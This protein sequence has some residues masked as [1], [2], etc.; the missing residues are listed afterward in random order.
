MVYIAQTQGCVVLRNSEPE[1]LPL[2]IFPL[3][4]QRRNLHVMLPKL[5][6]RQLRH[7]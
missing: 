7:N 2:E 4:K 3:D 5:I 6:Q 1:M